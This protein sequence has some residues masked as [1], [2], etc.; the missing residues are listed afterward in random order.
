MR[1]KSLPHCPLLNIGAQIQLFMKFLYKRNMSRIGCFGIQII[2]KTKLLKN[3]TKFFMIIIADFFR[4]LAL[5][6]RPDRNG[7]PM[8]ITSRHIKNL[9]SLCPPIPCQNISREQ[10]C[11]VTN[12]QGTVSIRPCTT[13]QYFLHL[14]FLISFIRLITLNFDTKKRLHLLVIIY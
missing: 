8:T 10:A 1:T 11:N 12:M 4:A 9:S 3:L 7:R 2:G 13:Y 5:L 6:F 14:S